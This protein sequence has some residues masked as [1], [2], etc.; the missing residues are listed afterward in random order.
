M[1]TEFSK[2]GLNEQCLE[3]IRLLGFDEPT[4]I[5]AQCIPHLLEGRDIIGKARTGSGKTAAFGLPLVQNIDI[6][7]KTPQALV[8]APTREL[9]I[10]VSEA[11]TSFCSGQAVR[12]QCIYGG[13]PYH[14]QIR[15]LKRGVSIIVGTPGRIIDLINKKVLDLSSTRYIVL[16]EADEMLRMGFIEDVETIISQTNTTRQMALFS[17]TMPPPIRKIALKFMNEATEIEVEGQKLS[18]SHIKQQYVLVH[19]KHKV[20]TLCRIL[21]TQVNESALIFTRTK[22]SCADISDILIERGMIADALHGDMGQEARERVLNKLRNK[23]LRFV[24]AT[25]V[26]ARGID[27]NHISHVINFDITNDLESYVHRIGRTGRAGREGKAITLITPR[28]KNRL[29]TFSRKLKVKIEQAPPPSLQ[30]IQEQ[31][32]NNLK[33]KLIKSDVSANTNL[34]TWYHE[35]TTD[36]DCSDEDAAKTLLKALLDFHGIKTEEQQDILLRPIKD[37]RG[38]KGKKD[39]SFSDRNEQ[40]IVINIGSRDQIQVGD[41]V[42]AISTLADIP[43]K[44]VGKIKI[45]DRKSFIG[46]PKTIA[47]QL[48]EKKSTISLKGKDVSVFERL[49]KDKLS[50][51][52]GMDSPDSMRSNKRNRRRDRDR[53]RRHR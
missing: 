38:D 13:T 53:K 15:S 18:T 22:Q 40:D 42:W 16:D 2:L 30:E 46:L 32:W 3:A 29:N 11:I 8:L 26:A 7:N 4:P 12:I 31:R 25:D 43:S 51:R 6:K 27:V 9:A 24:V 1:T 47:S 5:Q 10:Q 19:Q 39:L 45:M 14:D 50:R 52:F 49:G 37:K 48:I 35:L 44:M 20:E 36:L 28:E 17:A 23:T 41:I 34:N 33:L 21:E